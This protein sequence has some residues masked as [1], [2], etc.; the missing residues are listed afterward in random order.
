MSAGT[1]RAG[2]PT[3]SS[4]VLEHLEA[5]EGPSSQPLNLTPSRG[6]GLRRDDSL[7]LKTITQ[8]GGHS[9]AGSAAG[10]ESLEDYENEMSLTSGTSNLLSGPFVLRP[11]P[12]TALQNLRGR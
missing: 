12:Y 6:A 9:R 3:L 5:A 2:N 7:L 4:A 1:S 10:W 11:I 8:A